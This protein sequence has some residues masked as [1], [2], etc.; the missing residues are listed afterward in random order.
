M[1]LNTQIIISAR[2][3]ATQTYRRMGNELN[4]LKQNIASMGTAAAGVA[5]GAGGLGYLVDRTLQATEEIYTLHKTT[6]IATDTIQE[7]QF[8]ANQT[9]V[10]Q[11]RMNDA[12]SELTQRMGEAIADFKR[13]GGEITEMGEGFEAAGISMQQLQEITPTQT[14]NRLARAIRTAENEQ[15]ALNIAVKAFGDESGRSM[16]AMFRESEKSIQAYKQRAHELGIVLDEDLIEKSTEARKKV[17]TLTTV[18]GA[19]WQRVVGELG[20]EISNLTDSMADWVENNQKFLKQDVPGHISDTAESIGELKDIYDSLP[21]GVVGTAGAG[22]VGSMIFGRKAGG[23]IALLTGINA[24][25]DKTGD[26]IGDII[27]NIQGVDQNIQNIISGL[28]ADYIGQID[29]SNVRGFTD[30]QLEQLKQIDT[31]LT[32]YLIPSFDEWVNTVDKGSKKASQSMGEFLNQLEKANRTDISRIFGDIQTDWYKAKGGDGATLSSLLP[33]GQIMAE[34]SRKFQQNQKKFWDKVL[35]RGEGITQLDFAQPGW[36]DGAIKALEDYESS[37]MDIAANTEQAFSN[38]FST[39]EDALVRFVSTGKMEFK[40][41]AQSIAA[42]FARIGIRQA[43]TGPAANMMGNFFTES[44]HGNVFQNGQHLHQYAN[45][46]VVDQ[47]TVFPMAKGAGVMGEEGPEAVMP[48]TRTPGG[49]LGV[50]SQGATNVEVNVINN[51]SQPVQ[52]EKGQSRQDG[53]KMITDI[54]L[55]DIE[56]NRNGAKNRMQGA[57]RGA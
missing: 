51:S 54:V 33:S 9:G 20:P 49:D 32:D 29:T 38:S 22:L 50:K 30:A 40:D 12:M 13:T 45:G 46:G 15:E 31:Q 44:A 26:S 34:E 8:V 17:E 10:S 24:I 7:Y 47:P 28:Q 5:A 1:A 53:S 6:G 25:L 56:N 14:L 3:M 2:D 37:A 36:T 39:M 41:L 23:Y 19:Q 35:F 43:I 21:D 4:R 11:E 55:S 18:M 16:V 27:N 42:D 57:M 52:A 48:L